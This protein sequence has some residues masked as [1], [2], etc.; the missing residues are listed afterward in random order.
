VGERA[1]PGEEEEGLAPGRV[2]VV[3]EEEH[4]RGE[5]GDPA[6]NKLSRVG[7]RL[8]SSRERADGVEERLERGR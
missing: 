6:E 8:T 4:V 3:E 1:E 2:E 7:V 5:G